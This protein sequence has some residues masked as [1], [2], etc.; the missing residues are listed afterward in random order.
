MKTKFM[1]HLRAFHVRVCDP[2]RNHEEREELIV[3]P[4]EQLQAIQMVGQSSTELI[5]RICDRAQLSVI[6]IGRVEKRSVSLNLEEL[7]RMHG[8]ALMGTRGKVRE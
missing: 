6:S 2:G 4:K 3:I 8:V 7:W 5:E 1:I